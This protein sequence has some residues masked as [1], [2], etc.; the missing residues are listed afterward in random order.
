[1]LLPHHLRKAARAVF[2]GEDDI[3]H[4]LILGGGP[5]G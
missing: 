1:M 2:A 3:G 4:G 5:R